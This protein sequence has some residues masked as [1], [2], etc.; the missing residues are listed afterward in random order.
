VTTTEIFVNHIK[1]LYNYGNDIGSA[2]ENLEPPGTTSLK[3]RMQV[4]IEEDVAICT[5]EATIGNRV[6]SGLRHLQQKGA[7]VQNQHDKG[8]CIAF[9]EMR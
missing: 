4:S 5:G 3:P 1:K 2:L 6:Q 8:V 9:R 7:D